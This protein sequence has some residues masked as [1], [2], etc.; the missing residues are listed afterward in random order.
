MR[1]GAAHFE[2][3]FGGQP[4]QVPEQGPEQQQQQ[5]PEQPEP[6][7]EPEPEMPSAET[8]LQAALRELSLFPRLR[9]VT[10][11]LRVCPDCVPR[12]S[13]SR[14]LAIHPRLAQDRQ[15]SRPIG[16]TSHM[17]DWCGG[18]DG[19]SDW[20]A[21]EQWGLVE[22]RAVLMRSAPVERGISRNGGDEPG[23]TEP[24]PRRVYCHLCRTLGASV[25]G[26]RVSGLDWDQHAAAHWADADPGSPEWTAHHELVG[27]GRGVAVRLATVL[28]PYLS[29]AC[30]HCNFMV[31]SKAALRAHRRT[32][33]GIRG[34]AQ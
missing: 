22:H 13:D 21:E 23:P 16:T 28:R 25:E 8:E 33:H 15:P 32:W 26:C 9:V 30:I 12:V 6:Q 7:P 3:V 24:M 4:E 14:P 19:A 34:P 5:Q 17:C 29:M 1:P 2:V 27:R 10:V 18:R 11:L 31:A 20:R